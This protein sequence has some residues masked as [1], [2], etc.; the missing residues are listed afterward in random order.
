MT[1]IT[2]SNKDLSDNLDL[3][4]VVSI[5][6]ETKDLEDFEKRL[7]DPKTQVSN[8]DLNNDGEVDYLRIISK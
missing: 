7:N 5:F 3:E 6:G 2:A 4:G 8:L 1:T